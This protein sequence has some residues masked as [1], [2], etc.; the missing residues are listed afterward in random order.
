MEHSYFILCSDRLDYPVY[1]AFNGSMTVNDIRN[2]DV[3]WTVVRHL[4]QLDY[5][6]FF[7]DRCLKETY[8]NGLI[9][10]DFTF[11]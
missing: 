5:K 10:I 7:F 9:K 1:V 6:F 11:K 8:D 3:V 2:H 4:T